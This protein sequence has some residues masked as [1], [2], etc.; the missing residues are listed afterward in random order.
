MARQ[1]AKNILVLS[2][3]G[4]YIAELPDGGMR[5]GNTDG[6]HVDFVKDDPRSAA[7]L[8]LSGRGFDEIVEGCKSY[9]VRGE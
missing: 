4:H 9:L 2:A 5:A 1:P 7:L 8:S 3:C 6:R